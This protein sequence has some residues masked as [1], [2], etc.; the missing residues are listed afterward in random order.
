MTVEYYRPDAVEIQVSPTAKARLAKVL[1]NDEQA[2]ALRLSLKK[3]GCSGY[4]YDLQT[5]RM[6]LPDDLVLNLEQNL[7]LYVDPKDYALL[8]GLNIDYVKQGLQAKFV[9]QNPQQTGQCGCGESFS[10]V[11]P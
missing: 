8:R 7:L 1:A 6:A 11:K 9:Y 2:M 10:V 5:I 3:T 4:S